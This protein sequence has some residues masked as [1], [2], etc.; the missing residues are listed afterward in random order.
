MSNSRRWPTYLK[1]DYATRKLDEAVECV[2]VFTYYEAHRIEERT[3]NGWRVGKCVIETGRIWGIKWRI[4]IVM[5]AI[6]NPVDR[7]LI[8]LLKCHIQWSRS[9]E[10]QLSSSIGS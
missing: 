10:T 2:V 6:S 7:G 9:H 4:R 5:S 3:V 8:Q 1:H